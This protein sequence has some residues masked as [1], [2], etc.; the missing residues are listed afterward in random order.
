MINFEEPQAGIQ[1]PYPRSSLLVLP[2]GGSSYANTR[3]DIENRLCTDTP[4][5]HFTPS[6]ALVL[7]LPGP[8]SRTK[9]KETENAVE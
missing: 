5:G 6:L 9:A 7:L 4:R 8:V 1:G 3:R 2:S